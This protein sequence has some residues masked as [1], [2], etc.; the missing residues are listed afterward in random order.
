MTDAKT[1][2]LAQLSDL[3]Y[4]RSA[5]DI[6]FVLSS[7]QDT[8]LA[9]Y[10]AIDSTVLSGEGS[11]APGSFGFYGQVYQNGSQYV[12]AFRGTDFSGINGAHS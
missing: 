8:A 5:A 9:G 3:A 4:Q 6:P 11:S 10:T 2:A 7:E 1:I 12:I